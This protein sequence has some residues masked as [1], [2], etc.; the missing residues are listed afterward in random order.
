MLKNLGCTR[1]LVSAAYMPIEN[2]RILVQCKYIKKTY[3][4]CVLLSI[5]MCFMERKM[6]LATNLLA[7]AWMGHFARVLLLSLCHGHLRTWLHTSAMSSV[8]GNGLQS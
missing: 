6:I 4:V 2:E 5:N 3:T 1:V 7:G 8:G